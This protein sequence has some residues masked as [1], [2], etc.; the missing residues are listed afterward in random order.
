MTRL[1]YNQLYYF[2]VVA[3]EGS[4]KAACEKL[5]LTQPTISGQLK[6]LEEDLGFPLFDRKHRKLELNEN[7][8]HIYKKAEKIFVLGDELLSNMPDDSGL[9]RQAVTIGFTPSLPNSFLHDFLESGWQDPSHSLHVTNGTIDY[10]VEMLND[11]EIDLILSDTPYYRGT[12]RYR[13]INLGSQ[14]LTVVGTEKYKHLRKNFPH[15][16]NEQPYLSF[17]AKGQLQEDVDYF[18]RINNIRPDLIG[19]IDDAALIRTITEKGLCF[20]IL[21]WAAVDESVKQRRLCKI[22]ELSITSNRWAITTG[23]SSKKIPIRKLINN[24][25][26]KNRPNDNALNKKQRTAKTKPT[27]QTSAAEYAVSTK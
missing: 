9:Q 25:L 10:L 17:G 23:L 1:N 18:L 2:Y 5:H 4:I 6:T 19:A 13:S 8:R 7:G 20:S 11:G 27:G 24:F 16:L 14:S 22:G 15:S 3:S 12:T 21:P 26:V